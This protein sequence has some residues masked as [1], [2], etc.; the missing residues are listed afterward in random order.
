MARS[1]IFHRDGALSSLAS[2]PP[3]PSLTDE[4]YAHLS[5]VPSAHF[6]GGVACKGEPAVDPSRMLQRGD[7]EW[8]EEH[9]SFTQ[10]Q[11]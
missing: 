4:A 2:S 6:E 1:F 11:V 8:I 10:A 9:S 5:H 3:L 7:S